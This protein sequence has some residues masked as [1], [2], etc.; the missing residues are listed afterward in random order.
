MVTSPAPY[1]PAA[2]VPSN[3]PYSSGWSSVMTANRLV[4]RSSGGPLGTAQETSTPECSR[5]K[6][7]CR[8]LAWCSWITKLGSSPSGASRSRGGSAGTGSAVRSGSRIER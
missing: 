7:Q 2:M 1:S 6:S 8:L 5:R 3:V 4:S